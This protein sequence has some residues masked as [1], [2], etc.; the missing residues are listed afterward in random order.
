VRIKSPW[1]ADADTVK[2]AV[3]IGGDHHSDRIHNSAENLLGIGGKLNDVL[4]NDSATK[5]RYGQRGL[6]RMNIQGKHTSLNVQIQECGSS[7]ARK[8]A[9]RSLNDP[10]VGKQLLHDKRDG[11]S[12]QSRGPRQIRARNGLVVAYLVEDKCS[13]DL[14]GNLIRRTEFV[15][16]R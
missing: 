10:L 13:I 4:R 2:R 15:G 11:A 16:K 8:P 12:L 1:Q 9:H 3:A 6:R 5:V 7:A 14:P